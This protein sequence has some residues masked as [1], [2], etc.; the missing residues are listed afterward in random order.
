M[1]TT[2][3]ADESV[4]VEGLDQ[5]DEGL[6]EVTTELETDFQQENGGRLSFVLKP[7]HSEN[8]YL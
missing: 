7:Q 4:Q 8:Y 2:D 3:I 5:N 6:T 1:S